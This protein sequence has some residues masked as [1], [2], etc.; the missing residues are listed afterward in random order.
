MITRIG[1]VPFI[2]FDVNV[3]RP[4]SRFLTTHTVAFAEQ[5]GWRELTNGDLLAAA[6]IAGFDVRLTADLH[7]RYQ[8]N[9]I[10]RRIAIVALSTN[11]WGTL[12][13]H[14][15]LITDAVVRARDGT[16]EEITLPRPP[17]RRR[18]SAPLPRS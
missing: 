8:Q 2:L 11:R 17:L 15:G 18:G 3:P 7:L 14:P 9:L 13:A 1:S 10:G 6:E 16:N 4:V 12:R 5:R